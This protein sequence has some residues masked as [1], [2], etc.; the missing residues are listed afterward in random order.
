MSVAA[1]D[2][3]SSVYDLLQNESDVCAISERIA[4]IITR[5]GPKTGEGRDGRLILCDLGCGSG[6]ITLRL[7]EFGYE[8]IGIDQSPAMLS[9]ARETFSREGRD[10]LFVCQDI[11]RLDLFGCAD[12]FVALTDTLNHLTDPGAFRGLFRSLR[13]F[14][15]PGGLFIFDLLTLDFLENVRGNNEFREIEDRYALFWKNR[16]FKRSHLSRADMTLFVENANGTYD[17]SD[18]SVSER[19]YPA[20]TVLDAM[21]LADLELVGIFGGYTDS[22]PKKK[23]VRHLYVGRRR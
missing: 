14:L 9:E 8:I 20:E 15:R 2:S 22:R 16:F 3:L 6:K 17:R 19:Y 23:D 1:Y 4:D 11:S 7:S 5:S 18:F 10:A 13:H 21:C 12:V